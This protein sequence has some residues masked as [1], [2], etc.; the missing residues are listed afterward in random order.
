MIADSKIPDDGRP[1]RWRRVIDLIFGYDYFISYA[2]SDGREYAT[3]LLKALES[4]RLKCFLDSEEFAKGVNWRLEAR[5]AL[6]K[7]T[8]LVLVGSPAAIESEAVEN[9]V[10]IFHGLHRHII[11]ISFDGSMDH[12]SIASTKIGELIGPEIIRIDETKN[13][14]SSGPSDEV[15]KGLTTSFTILTQDQK[16]ARLFGGAA[17]LFIVI[18]ILAFSFW[19][20]SESNRRLADTRLSV[21][22]TRLNNS[23]SLALSRA[24]HDQLTSFQQDEL[25]ALLAVQAWTFARRGDGSTLPEADASL[26]SV[27][28]KRFFGQRLFFPYRKDR[29]I[30]EISF[31]PNSGDIV[32]AGEYS[33]WQFSK[34]AGKFVSHQLFDSRLELVDSSPEGKW[35]CGVA[36]RDL[37]DNSHS[38]YVLLFKS[39]ESSDETTIPAPPGNILSLRFLTEHTVLVVTDN[40]AFF[41]VER[42]EQQVTE[43]GKIEGLQRAWISP[44]GKKAAWVDPNSELFVGNLKH[45]GSNAD[46]IPLQTGNQIES[47]FFSPRSKLMGV[48]SDDTVYVIDLARPDVVSPEISVAADSGKRRIFSAALSTNRTLA[49]GHDSGDISLHDLSNLGEGARLTAE[50]NANGDAV[51]HLE[52]TP[53][54][55]TLLSASSQ[56]VHRWSL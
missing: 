7:T 53:D 19:F 26:R 50:I 46:K 41:E 1:L 13:A 4:Q 29:D 44:K 36:K 16:R 38:R 52:F 12:V 20:R 40:G 11:P 31:V 39:L 21:A 48:L 3:N 23:L 55:N 9:E 28:S 25:S 8:R 17:F 37:E 56:S 49:L 15:V 22:T 2:W 51:G 32:V 18:A 45:L 35:T 33:T 5:R 42:P 10:E 47:V 6:K 54:G 27:G 14:L 43:I 34:T 24:S 30:E